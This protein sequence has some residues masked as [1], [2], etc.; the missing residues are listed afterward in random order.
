[1]LEIIAFFFTYIL[2]GG[3][4]YLLSGQFKKSL[5]VSTF[6]ILLLL[7]IISQWILPGAKMIGVFDFNMYMNFSLQ[8]LF[9]GVLLGRG[10]RAIKTR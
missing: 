4:G 5:T 6:A 8:A 7:T 9:G 1:M 3:I 10:I 2:F